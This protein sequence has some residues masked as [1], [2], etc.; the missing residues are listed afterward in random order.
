MTSP[1][2]YEVTLHFTDQRGNTVK[3]LIG[4]GIYIM[5]RSPECEIMF[6]PD[7]PNVSRRHA[8]LTVAEGK[9][10]IEDLDSTTGT[11]V[12]GRILHSHV[13]EHEDM[14]R[15]GSW[16]I[17]ISL[18]ETKRKVSTQMRLRRRP[19]EA[20]ASREML[21]AELEEV[22]EGTES[23]VKEVGKRILGQERTVR[24]VWA[25]ILAKSHCLM[26]GVPGLAKTYMVTTFSEV[27]G[28]KFNRI[29]FTPDLMPMDVIGSHVMQEGD[30]GKRRFEFVQGPVFSQLL[31]A[32]EIN[33]TPP[34][35]QSALL[36]AMQERQ[37]TV[38]SKT[39][40]LP[41]PFCVIASQNPIEQEGTYPLPEAQ[42]DR[43][44]L[45]IDLDYPCRDDEASILIE[46]TQ[47]RIPKVE[48][49]LSYEKILR[50]QSIVDDICISEELAYVVADLVRST[51]PASSNADA[52][53][54]E[55]V[56][57]GAGPRA[58]QSI[59]R[60]AKA[61]AAMDGRPGVSQDDVLEVA[62]PV[63]KHRIGFNYRA[64]VSG[65]SPEEHVSRLIK[66]AK[67]M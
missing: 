22:R 32:D 59:I 56:D 49:V 40:G 6:A 46:T 48:T 35:T 29:Q 24:L 37:V 12:N 44:M 57:W 47:G 63:L 41:A 11:M 39:Y 28:L 3:E 62:L 18:P 51:R 38:A 61:Y 52:S 64:R 34:K 25:T 19:D 66:H 8:K 20:P 9:T 17:E 36:E 45:S 33:R 60:A 16:A 4:P 15:I 43:F 30:D 23:V 21:H 58:G 13:L 31:L 53:L 7:D 55:M 1:E 65:I 27:L 2:T 54:R 26:I 10:T 14:V 50:F 5:G 42:L 67:W